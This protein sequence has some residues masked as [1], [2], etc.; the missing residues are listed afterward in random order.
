MGTSVQLL[1]SGCAPAAL[2]EARRAIA[3]Y[4]A[5]WIR[6]VPDS[7]VSRVNRRAGEWTSVSPITFRLIEAAIRASA[8]TGGRFDPTVL[9]ALVAA[10]YDRS[11]EL[12]G[13]DAGVG[14]GTG[15]PERR[16][17]AGRPVAPW[18]PGCGAIDLDERTMSIR[19]VEGTGLDLGG[20]G[21]GYAADLVVQALLEAGASGALANLG[22]DIRAAGDAPRSEGWRIGADHP[23]TGVAL[24]EMVVV[25]GAVATSTSTRRHWSVDGQS[26]HH[27][28]DPLTAAPA[29][30]GLISVTVV[31]AKAMWAE[32]LAK[33][34]FVAGA[35]DG[36]R[37]I[38]DLGATG[39]MVTEEGDVLAV[40]GLEAFVR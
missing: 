37:L 18:V 31:A 9:A 10:G 33:A 29:R 27:L 13:V 8:L 15:A 11:F 26:R 36:A 40:E 1:A 5:L 21:K 20:I 35:V 23:T 6:F 34:A 22:G 38:A 12:V 4:E 32:V 30:S 14:A 25:D 24:P 28:I 39:F 17:D 7:D 16:S 3:A 2:D 19:L